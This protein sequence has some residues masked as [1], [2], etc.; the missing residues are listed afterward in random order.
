MFSSADK[1]KGQGVGSAYMELINMLKEKFPTEFDVRINQYSQSDI[2][3]YHTVD[4]FFYVSTFFKKRRGTR[5]GYVHF[6]PE[7]LEGS[8]A[9]FSPFQKIFDW[10]LIS[11]Y[12]RMDQLVVVNPSFIPKLGEAGI[13][14]T[15]VTYIPNFVS[16]EVFYEMPMERKKELRQ[17][18]G[19]D[20]SALI[21]LG[22][23][24]IQQ[25]KGLDDFIKLANDN[26]HIQF[27]WAG[28]FSFGKITDGYDR[29]KKVYDN[30]PAN[31]TFTGII[32]RSELVKYYNLADLFLL[33][34]FNELFPMSILEGFNCGT[35]IMLRDLEL[36]HTIIEGDYIPTKDVVEM[37]EAL[38]KIEA[39]RNLLEEYREKSRKAG[40]HYSEENVSKIWYEYYNKYSKK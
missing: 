31:L 4:P 21:V 12:R 18:Y 19:F 33:P 32:D 10:Y 22:S 28:G 3:H 16:K 9:L 37:Q 17:T 6:L 5:I 25:R 36:Y 2:S 24:Q 20:D 40:A 35:P 30:P 26:P 14:T 34:S 11:F 27:V 39:D 1:V 15:K 23:G 29:Y 13:D 38:S 7:T 8:I